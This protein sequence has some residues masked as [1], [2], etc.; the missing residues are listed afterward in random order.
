MIDITELFTEIYQPQ[1]VLAIMQA[2]QQK[3]YIEAYDLDEDNRPINAHPMSFEDSAQLSDILKSSRQ[4]N[5]N[6][7][8]P[9]GLLP[10]NVLYLHTDAPGFAIWHTAARK[11]RLRFIKDLGIPSGEAFIPPMIWKATKQELTVFAI[12]TDRPLLSTPL[13]HAPFFNIHTDGQVCM[14]TV[15]VESNRSDSL[16]AFIKNWEGYFFDSYFSH[17]ISKRSPV[18]SNIVQL[19]KKLITTG[20]KFP[21]AELI[22]TTLTIEDIII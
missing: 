14:G 12:P 2:G 20:N 18:R 21:L 10:K 22:Q 15:D 16:E 4:L 19:W 7:L 17:L 1:K 11:V 3:V 9:E 5:T 8:K 6:Y 13:C